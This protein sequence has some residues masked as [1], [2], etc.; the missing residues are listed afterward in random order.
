[1]VSCASTN[2]IQTFVA[3]ASWGK[4]SLIR[5]WGSKGQKVEV[6]AGAILTSTLRRVLTIWF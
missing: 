3:S 5:F 4:D 1:V 6:I 2:V